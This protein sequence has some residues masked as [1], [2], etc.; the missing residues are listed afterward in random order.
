MQK[1]VTVI[2]PTYNGMGYLPKLFKALKSQ[3]IS[4]E[5]LVIDSSSSDGTAA[6][7]QERANRV[8]TIP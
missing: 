2:I 8:I 4:F 6:F 7:V 5:L 3:T 1:S